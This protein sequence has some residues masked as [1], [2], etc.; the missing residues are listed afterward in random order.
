MTERTTD[1]FLWIIPLLLAIFGILMIFSLTS[2]TSLEEY[3]SPF[4]LGL[5]Q[6]EWLLAGIFAMIV[7]FMIP[8]SF[9]E[10]YSGYLWLFSLFLL[11]LTLVPGVGIKAGGARRWIGAGMIRF[12]P[13]ELAAMAVAIHLSKLLTRSKKQGVSAFISV[14]IP[15]LIFS[16]IPLLFQPNIGGTILIFA[17]AMAVHV[18]CRGWSWPLIAG[19]TGFP[20]FFMLF[21]KAGYRLRRYVA[22]LDPWEQPMDSGFQV[23]Q[24]LVAF[25]N[26]GVFGVGVGKGLQK[27]NYLPAAHTDYIFAAVGEEFGFAGTFLV[28]SLFLIWTT[29]ALAAFKAASGFHEALIWALTVSVLLPMFI[30]LGGVLKLM[31]LT[32]IPLPFISY[33]GSSLFFMWA[34]IGLL[35]RASREA[36][37]L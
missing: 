5:R 7:M 21:I 25:S 3:G 18:H 24:G 2:H 20:F 13:I 22:F 29:R 19:I 23:I 33:G 14:T 36:V 12:Q 1:P 27:L 35:M 15:V 26:G 11:V 8:V 37:R 30:N 28:L 10:K 32:G 34:R 4:A 6:G 31:P 9:W 17:L 16:V